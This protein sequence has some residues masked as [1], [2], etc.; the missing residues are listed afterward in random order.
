[1]VSDFGVYIH[2]PWCRNLCPYCDFPVAVVGR[3]PIPHREYLAAIRAELAER[4]KELSG[5]RLLSIYLGGGTP[6]LWEAGCLAEL[7]AKVCETFA[8]EP[9]EVTLEANPADCTEA[10]LAAWR[11]AGITRLSIG[12]QSLAPATL[13]SLGRDHRMGE[14][15]A[16]VRAALGAGFASIS[17]DVIVG[18]PGV[19]EAGR[20]LDP[21][22]TG[23]AA[24]GPPHLS[25]YELTIEDRTAFGKAARRGALRPLS[26]DAL[27]DIYQATHEALTAAGYEH[28]EISSYARPGHRSRH[29]SLYW[30]GCEFLGLGAGAASFVRLGGGGGRRQT[31]IRSAHAYLRARG[32]QRVAEIETLDAAQVAADRLWLGLRTAEGVPAG[33]LEGRPEVLEWLLE[34][35]LAEREAGSIRPTLRGFLYA[36]QVA[37]RVL[38]G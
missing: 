30:R 10:N 22:V 29:N 27:A 26:E 21:S 14:G 34:Q 33:D 17:A 28:Y 11:E 9:L 1:M 36:N 25:V 15:A 38:A 3:R 4:A 20:A 2:F 6:S 7:R 24:L 35:R 16:A 18:T 19:A 32:G 31:N 23:V 5:G 37:A 13:V 12:V 8:A